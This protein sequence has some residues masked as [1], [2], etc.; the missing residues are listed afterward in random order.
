MV[1]VVVVVVSFWPAPARNRPPADA[2]VPTP[3]GILWV[4]SPT[5][6]FLCQPYDAR[7]STGAFVRRV[8]LDRQF[9]SFTAVVAWARFGGIGRI[10][11]DLDSL[12]GRGG[13]ARLI[14]GIDEGIATRPGLLLALRHFSEVYVLHDRP[15][16]TFHPKLYLAEGKARAALLV[17]SGNLTA[18]GLFSNYEAALEATFSLPREAGARALVEARAYV[19]RL[20]GDAGV[21]LKLDEDVVE[22]LVADPR[23][24]VSK[25]ELRRAGSGRLPRGL[26]AEDVDPIADEAGSGTGGRK[27]LFGASAHGKAPVPSLPPAARDELR[28][29]EGQTADPAPRPAPAGSGQGRAPGSPGRRSAL[30]PDVQ[31]LRIPVLVA[32]LSKTRGTSQANF[33]RE[34]YEGYFGA[35]LGAKTRVRL[36]RVRSDGSLPSIEPRDT[37][38]VVSRNYRLELDGLRGRDY[39]SGN[40]T[41]IAIFVQRSQELFYYQALWPS[42]KGHRQLVA[43]LDLAE[44]VRRGRAR[45]RQRRTTIE[46]L[47]AAWP[48]CPVLDAIEQS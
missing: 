6:D 48:D 19:N 7:R 32:E 29:L 23:Y 26:E 38:E 10:G 27:K 42:D 9:D 47:E 46:Q 45:M 21:C 3:Y 39:P 13:V 41:P 28:R 40:Q 16:V 25:K 12:R 11:D 20:R 37:V 30:P 15:G 44:G 24:G 8:L 14:V 4:V 33:H 5:V 35:V 36:Q 2:R 34:H 18:G 31:R 43:Y 17:G 1:V 22:R